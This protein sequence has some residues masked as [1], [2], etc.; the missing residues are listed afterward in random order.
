M[1]ATTRVKQLYKTKVDVMMSHTVTLSYFV[2]L[3]HRIVLD[4]MKIVFHVQCNTTGNRKK[5]FKVREL[6]GIRYVALSQS[7]APLK[8]YAGAM[9]RARFY[10]YRKE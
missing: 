9:T 10:F 7:W 1:M 8:M 6:I 4:C 5:S 3:S 2:G